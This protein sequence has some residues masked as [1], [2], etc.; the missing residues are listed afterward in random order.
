MS[1]KLSRRDFLKLAGIGL[2]GL[3]APK[4]EIDINPHFINGLKVTKELTEAQISRD[5][6]RII[7]SRKLAMVWLFAE[8]SAKY[9]KEL[10]LGD[11]GSNMEHYLYGN[12]EPID[13]SPMLEKV[14]N[15]EPEFFV[16]KLLN[17]AVNQRE[18]EFGNI[19]PKKDYQFTN[20]VLKELKSDDGIEIPLDA[21]EIIADSYELF[22]AI[23]GARYTLHASEASITSLDNSFALHV[24]L[25]NG[26]D[27]VAKDKYYW[28]VVYGIHLASKSSEV[29]EHISET[30]FDRFYKSH[31][32]VQQTLMTLGLSSEQVSEIMELYSNDTKYQV[33]TN[34]ATG[35]Y[36][37]VEKVSNSLIGMPD[38]VENDLNLLKKLG[39]QEFEM[40]GHVNIPNRLELIV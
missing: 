33:T 18:A 22:N 2:A 17:A 38:L 10:G 5:P 30:I 9:S 26:V 32:M 11:A 14:I 23:G 12:G 20:K 37:L 16:S 15:R 25:E 35:T 40:I 3:L 34:M 29:V 36:E 7:E 39:A 24:V 4:I 27:I 6:E 19:T 8:T 13:I 31:D 21:R 1:D 28:G